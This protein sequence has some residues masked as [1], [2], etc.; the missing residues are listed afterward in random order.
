MSIAYPP[1]PPPR[2]S[3]FETLRYW[4]AISADPVGFVG[5]RFD[6]H[7]DPYHA[8]NGDEHLYV[9]KD[10]AHI[11]EI[12]VSKAGAFEKRIDELS[13]VLGQGLLNSEGALW[14]RQRRMIQPAFHRKAI[15]EYAEV[16]TR[17]TEELVDEWADGQVRE[18]GDDMMALT[19]RIVCKCLFDHDS[20][21][22]EDTVGG[23]MEALHEASVSPSLLPSWL[24]TPARVR[25]RR[26]RDRLWSLI[27]D[28]VAQRRAAGDA[29]ARTDLLSMLLCATDDGDSMSDTQLRDELVTLFLAGH[30]TTSHGLTWAFYLLSEHPDVEARLHDAVAAGEDAYVEWVVKEALRMYPPAYAVPRLATERVEIGGWTL[31]P[32]AEVIIWLYH[33]HHDPRWYPE[34]EAFRPERFAP[35]ADPPVDKRAWLPFGAGQ[36]LCIGRTFAELEMKLVLQAVCPRARLKLVPGHKVA[37]RPRVTLVPRHGMKMTVVRK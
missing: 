12:L 21:A 5:A 26:A 1:G 24:P 13:A 34:P 36:R 9:F 30:E 22:D 3:F 4:K 33:T 2:T 7:G 20:R 15:A 27:D 11:H 23:A 35:D 28:M 16:M 19:L 29:D 25:V 8:Q 31:E 14:K 37:M 6:A 18:I 10:P 17:Y 32:G